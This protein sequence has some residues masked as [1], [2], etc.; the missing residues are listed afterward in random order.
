[1]IEQIKIQR[2]RGI[3]NR[4]NLERMK[5]LMKRAE[6]GEKLVIGFIGGSI[7]QG[8]LAS[9]PELCYAYHVYEWWKSTFPK[10]EFAFL[11]AGI[12]A[13]TSQLGAARV[14]RDLLEKNP[15]FVVVEF[16]VND[17]SNEHFLETYEGLVRTIY[18][19]EKKPAVLLVH[20]V[21]YD[22]GGNAQIMHAKVGRHYNLPSVSMQS[23]I[24]PEVV[25]GAIPNRE[26]TP[27]DL[28]PNDLGHELVASVVTYYLDQINKEKEEAEEKETE[29]PEPLTQNAYE[30]S[31]RYQNYNCTP[32]MD[33][34]VADSSEQSCVADCFKNGWTASEEGSSISF[35]VE[36]SC[37]AVQ[38]RRTIQLPAPVAEVVIDGDTEHALLLDA[39]FDETW[40]DKLEL[41]TIAEH[42]EKKKHIVE[43]GLVETHKD[44]KLPFYLVSVIGS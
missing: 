12:G 2:E 5:N 44:D 3:A 34:F 31:V 38:Y 20:N 30:D 28:H 39:N 8:S 14:K 19:D 18:K 37:L 15:D 43:I 24:Y 27:D 41:M 17:E 42:V 21:R 35:E 16:S 32:T 9:K 11:N 7:T 22:D 29:M 6:R 40:G 23:S 13:T 10:S 36:G 26:M 33:G 4:G 25:S 1:M